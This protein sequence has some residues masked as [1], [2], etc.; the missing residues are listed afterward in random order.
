[1]DKIKMRHS[2]KTN[3]LSIG[4]FKGL[5]GDAT[6]K[7]I[8][9]EQLVRL[10]LIALATDYTNLKAKS[11]WSKEK[12]TYGS[13]LFFDNSIVDERRRWICHHGSTR[14]VH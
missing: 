2:L 5:D 7:H 6:G 14:F 9:T 8:D 3:R 4:T 10:V 12:L 13:S 11:D 1:M